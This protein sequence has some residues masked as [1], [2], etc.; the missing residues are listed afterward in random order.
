M[1]ASVHRHTPDGAAKARGETEA[2]KLDRNLEE[3]N[4]ELRVVVT[5]VQVLFAFLLVVPFDSRFASVGS[6][7]RTVYLVTLLLAAA[8]AA[9]M[10]GPSATHRMLFKARE[11]DVLVEISNVLTIAGLVFMALAIGGS[12]MVVI[13]VLEGPAAGL[14]AG[15]GGVVVIG[16]MWFAYPLSRRGRSTADQ[17]ARPIHT[18]SMPASTNTADSTS[19]PARS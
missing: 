8:A 16:L 11:K 3:L 2:E 10:M 18:C 13:S 17:S 5:G 9:C 7:E 14:A 12:L 15:A 4:G 6:F 1:A 19:K